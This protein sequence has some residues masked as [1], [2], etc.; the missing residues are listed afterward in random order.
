LGLISNPRR[1]SVDGKTHT[2]LK[3]Q[4]IPSAV[5]ANRAMLAVAALD[6]FAVLS[7]QWNEIKYESFID[8]RKHACLCHRPGDAPVDPIAGS[9]A[10]PCVFS[11]FGA[12]RCPD[13]NLKGLNR[14]GPRA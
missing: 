2:C 3:L 13:F 1:R 10:P 8:V 9:A 6:S 12:R 11:G 5:T 4:T 14:R 7:L